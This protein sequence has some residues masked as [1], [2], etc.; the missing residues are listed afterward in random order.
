MTDD[1][2][3]E[4]VRQKEG[5]WLAELS[6]RGA[7][8]SMTFLVDRS[9][10]LRTSGRSPFNLTIE[11]HEVGRL[12]ECV[13]RGELLAIPRCVE[14]GVDGPNLSSVHDPDWNAPPVTD[15]WLDRVEQLEGGHWLA[16][17]RLNGDRGLYEVRIHPGTPAL[18][19]PTGTI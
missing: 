19:T 17:L 4:A 3:L 1:V 16:R 9:G 6:F 13:R 5:E 12:V 15:V 8:Y 7:R 2:V 11:G 10:R 14:V 18:S